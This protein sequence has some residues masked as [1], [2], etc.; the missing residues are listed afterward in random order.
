MTTS[1]KPKLF[2]AAIGDVRDVRTWSGI[3]Y[4]LLEAARAAGVD[5]TGMPFDLDRIRSR[6]A[7]ALWSLR[8]AASFRLPKAYQ[9]S[10]HFHRAMWG[11][12]ETPPSGSILINCFPAYPDHLLADKSLSL[13]VFI[14]Q[15]LR[16]LFDYYEQ[17]QIIPTDLQRTILAREARTYKR[18]A[19]IFAQSDW[20]RRS[21]IDDYGVAADKVHVLLPG[22]N[23]DA[24]GLEKWEMLPHTQSAG[25][26]PLRL[27]FVGKDWERKGLDRLLRGF[28]IARSR[29][30]DIAMDVIGCAPESLPPTLARSEGVE[31]LGFV[32]KHENPDRFIELVDRFDVGCLLSHREAGGISLLEFARL[33]KP[34]IA[35]DTGGA[36]EYT[37]PGAATL[38]KPS[39]GDERIADAITTL[40]NDQVLARQQTVA[41]NA[42]HQADWTRCVTQL[43]GFLEDIPRY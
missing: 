21:I 6:K 5:M 4:H 31:W 7:L 37:V 11:T 28:A 20:A 42:R 19:T 27:G 41:W 38:I 34:V 29:T 35:P 26:R 8:R 10:A 40:A 43:M 14:D 32:N 36:P 24:R 3:P 22:A 2:L 18:C 12:A 17:G 30:P 15:T 25:T 23:L 33:G 16:Q 39:D 1:G 9:Y 13:C